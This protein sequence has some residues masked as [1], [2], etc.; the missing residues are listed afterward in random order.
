MGGSQTSKMWLVLELLSSKD[1]ITEDIQRNRIPIVGRRE[2]KIWQCPM[3]PMVLQMLGKGRHRALLL[4]GLSVPPARP[5]LEVQPAPAAPL[6]SPTQG[7][8]LYH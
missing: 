6:G 4:K 8:L 5:R 1:F 2:V 7:I 3:P